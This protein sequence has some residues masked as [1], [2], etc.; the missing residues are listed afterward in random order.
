MLVVLTSQYRRFARIGVNVI[1]MRRQELRE[2]MVTDL[3]KVNSDKEISQAFQS[4]WEARDD[5]DTQEAILAA[6]DPKLV[7]DVLMAVGPYVVAMDEDEE[8][9]RN[10]ATADNGN[11][12][13]WV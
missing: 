2:Q 11:L 5:P 12:V 6:L 4:V 3:H 13:Y 1:E 9:M 8:L 7:R 10:E